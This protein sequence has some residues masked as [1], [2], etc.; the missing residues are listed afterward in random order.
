MSPACEC[1][2]TFDLLALLSHD[3]HVAF[4]MHDEDG[5]ADAF[6]ALATAGV[7]DEVLDEFAG[8]LGLLA[9]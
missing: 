8:P 2:I 6:L 4:H 5:M 3:Q 9:N 1:T 7:D